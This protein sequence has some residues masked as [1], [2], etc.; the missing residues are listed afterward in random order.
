M[1]LNIL[2]VSQYYWPENFRINELSYELKKLGHNVTVLTG[3]PNYPSGKIFKE[4][5]NNKKKYTSYKGIRI[6]RVPIIPRGG[7]KKQL[8][9]N[10]L[11]FVF[12]ATFI[13]IFKLINLKCDNVIVFQTSPVFVGIPS[14]IISFIKNSSQII[15]VLD[16][17]PETLSALGIIKRKWQIKILR[18][19]VN[20][21]YSRCD[22][23][24]TQSKR[25]IK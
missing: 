14:S 16:L 18:I 7:T 20:F 6:I 13:G 23:I 21:I 19:I 8:I 9:I 15:W 3:Y 11:S 4:F 2:I 1:S 17:W 12:S 10:Y 22:L 5:L 24:L 25:F